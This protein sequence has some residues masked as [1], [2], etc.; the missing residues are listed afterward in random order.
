[1]F[2]RYI[3][4]SW[5]NIIQEKTNRGKKNVIP[6]ERLHTKIFLFSITI[7]LQVIYINYIWRYRLISTVPGNKASIP[8]IWIYLLQNA[9]KFNQFI[10]KFYI[11]IVFI[12]YAERKEVSSFFNDVVKKQTCKKWIL[13]SL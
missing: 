13:L 1:M 9:I 10:K 12:I 3:R 5:H 11:I 6:L 2:F 8:Q 4:I 7:C